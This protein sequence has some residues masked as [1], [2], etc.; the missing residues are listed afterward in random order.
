MAWTA[1][2]FSNA[3]LRSRPAFPAL[4]YTPYIG[5]VSGLAL[6]NSLGVMFEVCLPAAGSCGGAGKAWNR[7][8]RFGARDC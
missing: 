5:H 6:A 8:K 2:A 7:R 3:V 1:R 4:G